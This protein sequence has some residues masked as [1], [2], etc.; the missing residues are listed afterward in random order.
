MALAHLLLDSLIV[1]M[2]IA[3]LAF[4]HLKGEVCNSACSDGPA[5]VWARSN[6]PCFLISIYRESP[7]QSKNR[8]QG[9]FRLVYP[10]SA[11]NRSGRQLNGLF[12]LFQCPSGY[13]PVIKCLTGVGVRG[14]S[15]TSEVNTA[16]N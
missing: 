8:N 3:D 12:L 9:R 6:S 2:Q 10:F 16:H 4:S 14:E 5:N 13:I 7:A 15:T 11:S 1:T